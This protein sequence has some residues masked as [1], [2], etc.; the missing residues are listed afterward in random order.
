MSNRFRQPAIRHRRH[1]AAVAL[2]LALGATG[3]GVVLAEPLMLVTS[4]RAGNP[5]LFLVDLES[6]DSFNLTRDPAIDAYPA[7]SPDGKKI[8][9]SAVHEGFQHLFSIDPDGSNRQQLTKDETVDRV[10]A[11][12]P[13]SKK[14]A[15]CRRPVAGGSTDIYVM[16]ADGGNVKLVQENGF[17]PAWSPDGM[18]IAFVSVR[19]GAG[20][21]L[22]LMQADG[23]DVTELTTNDNPIGF[24]Y[25]A[26]SPDGK[27][28]AFTELVENNDLEVHIVDADGKNLKRLTQLTGLNTYAAWSPDGKQIAFQHHDR[29]RAPG[30]VY[31]MDADGGNA[32]VIPVLRS[33]RPVEGGR[34][35]WK[36]K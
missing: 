5:D 34:L 12:S 25:P 2:C 1:L 23:S 16:D 20:F 15:F 4:S 18:Q 32:A 3:T 13:D 26:W 21:H 29:N 28:I 7:W 31:L 36:P 14:I 17:D 22:Y 27:K 30:P 8:V 6:G 33:E 24:A 9:W 11:F 19:N 10:P 35:V